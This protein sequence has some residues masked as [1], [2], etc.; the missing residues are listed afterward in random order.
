M[1]W[2]LAC[3][4]KSEHPRALTIKAPLHLPAYTWAASVASW[5]DALMSLPIWVNSVSFLHHSK[6]SYLQSLL[7]CWPC[8][9]AVLRTP[10]DHH[11]QCPCCPLFLTWRKP[12]GMIWSWYLSRSLGSSNLEVLF[13]PVSF[14]GWFKPWLQDAEP[15]SKLREEEWSSLFSFFALKPHF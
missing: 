12:P 4:L 2:R 5:L 1:G 6:T 7:S 9:L 3:P 13:L 8:T 10:P 15:F 14:S 11:S